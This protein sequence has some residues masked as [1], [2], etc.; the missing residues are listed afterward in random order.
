MDCN[1]RRK[2]VNFDHLGDFKAGY[3]V[4]NHHAGKEREH[5]W[6]CLQMK[7][8]PL[9]MVQTTTKGSGT[10]L[11]QSAHESSRLLYFLRMENT[12]KAPGSLTCTYADSTGN[13][14]GFDPS[15]SAG[16]L[17][18]L[19][20]RH[21]PQRRENRL[22]RPRKRSPGRRGKVK[23]ASLSFRVAPIQVRSKEHA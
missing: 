22:Q 1:P 18:S 5:L 12:Q 16:A 19:F 23:I 15:A 8:A 7:N 9:D 4:T 20:S 2:L 21:S 10:L 6:L 3:R 11:L 17:G 14:R 13:P